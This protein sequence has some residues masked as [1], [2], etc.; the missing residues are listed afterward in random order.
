[1]IRKSLIVVIL[2]TLVA[3]AIA[4]L[5][6]SDQAIDPPGTTDPPGPT[7]PPGTSDPPVITALEVMSDRVFPSGSTEIV[8][9]ASCPDGEELS[10]EWSCDD[11]EIEGTG[12]TV[13]W[14]APD[15][16]GVYRITVTVTAASGGQDTRDVTISVWANRPP[17]ITSLTSNASW[18]TP[19]GDLQITCEAEDPDGDELS[20]SWTATDGSISGTG[21]TVTWTA[22]EDVGTYDITVVVSD[23]HG[24]SATRTLGVSVLTGQPPVIESL[25]VESDRVFPSGST[26]IVCIAS[27]PDGEEL[28]YEWSCDDGEIEGTGA[29]VTWTAPDSEGTYR[30]TVTVTAGIGGQDTRDV[31]ISVLAN[32]P[33][34]ITSLTS[35]AA[36]TTPAGDLQITCEAEDPDGDELSY[37]WTATDGSISGTGATV[38]WTAPED[39][40]T[41]DITVVVSDDHG[42]SAT[43]TLS[44]SVLTGQPPVIESLIVEA[45][46]R[47]LRETPSGYDVGEGRDFQIHCTASH[48]DDLEFDYEWECERGEIV[49]ISEDGSMITWRA[50]YTRGELMITVTVTD[51]HDNTVSKSVAL[52]VVSCSRFG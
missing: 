28:S 4:A 20:Y 24:G 26:E 46:H 29:T 6:C 5:S 40:G 35:D 25:I 3:V 7:D 19:A 13:T 16:E 2:V 32:R 39:V 52:E 51:I 30:I 37:L 14:T 31:T 22:P 18:T 48:P 23:D 8:C 47:Y 15:S 27:S 36:W 45:D 1:M 11:G 44:V 9:V 42:G 49:E 21:A 33:P 10:Y 41:Y 38:T 17:I 50:P 43:R 12:A 34:I